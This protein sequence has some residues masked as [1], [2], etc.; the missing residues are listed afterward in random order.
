VTIKQP[1]FGYTS[2]VRMGLHYS[3]TQ[4]KYKIGDDGA[5][6]DVRICEIPTWLLDITD[7]LSL[8]AF[9][10][11]TLIGRGNNFQFELGTN[12]GFF[13]FGADKGDSSNF[14]C[15]LLDYSRQGIQLNPFL[16]HLNTIK[17][18]YV[19]GPSSA[20]T[21]ATV[22]DEGDLSIGSVAT[23]RNVQTFPQV[24]YDQA[25][26]REVSR[27]GVVSSIDLGTS[28]DLVETDL[29][30]EMRPG[31]CAALISFLLS[32]RAADINIGTPGNT[33]LFGA[34]NYDAGLYRTKL[35][36]PE[37]KITH[38]NFNLFKTRLKFWMKE[39]IGIP[40]GKTTELEGDME[41]EGDLELV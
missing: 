2:I 8:E 22:E 4:A 34:T 24:D 33:Y 16:Q 32:V 30:L 40:G 35:L 39:R 26:Y 11:N 18:V 14:I 10:E 28:A 23:L 37:I 19:S 17:F 15:S 41:L 13:P 5:T 21:Q 12:S 25:I 7:Q 38:D 1:Y 9:F 6:F 29:D 36:S 27:G 31:N 20:Y 3:R